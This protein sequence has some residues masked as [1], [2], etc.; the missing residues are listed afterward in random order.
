VIR[1]AAVIFFLSLV[2]LGWNIN[3]LGISAAYSDPI[4]RVR[5]QDEAVYVN[6]AIRMTQDGD[7]MTPK[8]MGRLLLY[9]P[10]LLMWMCAVCIRL[11]GLSLFAVRLPALLM[12][13]A[14]VAGVFI[15]VA[16]ARSVAAG[17][18]ASAILL[19]SPFWQTFSRLCYTD[20]L[21]SSS[22]LLALQ[23]VAFDPRLDRH[24]TRIAFG[25]FASASILAK[26]IGGLLPFAALVLYLILIP[27]EGRPRLAALAET[28]LIALLVLIPWHLYEA[29]VHPKWFWADYVQVELFGLGI[30]PQRTGAVLYYIRRF[31]QMDPVALIF[32]LVGLAGAFGFVKLRSKPVALLA[33][34]WAIVAVGALCA[35][36][37]VNLPYVVLILPPLCVL[38]GLC[39]PS[40]VDRH[41]WPVLCAVALLFGAKLAGSGAPWSL[42]PATPPM[43]GAR[44]MR[45]YY[46]LHRDTDLILVDPDDS[47]YDATIPLPHVRYCVFDPSNWVANFAPHYLPLG[48]TLTAEQFANLPALQPGFEKRL[49][50]WGVDSPEPVGT[51]ITVRTLPELAMVLR[52]RP[53]SDFYIP[54][55][56]EKSLDDAEQRFQRVQYSPERVFLLSRTAGPRKE[57]I[58]TI[59]AHW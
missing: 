54:A 25:V 23:A 29:I 12:G 2:L 33:F 45:D 28:L 4:D 8:F 21:A 24:R 14:G 36:Q 26:S 43:E 11:F 17:I 39:I 38:G 57:P 34:S 48:I 37:S 35:Y 56:W 9:K 59:P 51:T 58:P 13:A 3:G 16:H 40:F 5:A 10:P 53:D 27:R 44:A 49:R 19:L 42:R 50:E 46:N 55:Y 1:Y 41:M 20:V 32:G 30:R 15:W 47:F 22:A 7:W 52:A 31:I 6:S 18:L